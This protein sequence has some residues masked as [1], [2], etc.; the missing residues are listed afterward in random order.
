MRIVNLH[1]GSCASGE[2]GKY[3]AVLHCWI[4]YGIKLKTLGIRRRVMAFVQRKRAAEGGENE[5][6]VS[7][8][9]LEKRVNE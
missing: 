8:E 3:D 6:N 2:Q 4:N 1:L 5:W 7:K 9:G